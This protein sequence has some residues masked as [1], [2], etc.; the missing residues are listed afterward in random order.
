MKAVILD[1]PLIWAKA[2]LMATFL[3][4]SLAFWV[5][6]DGENVVSAFFGISTFCF[7]AGGSSK[8]SAT[9]E[10][11]L[12]STKILKRLFVEIPS[13][14]VFG[15]CSTHLDFGAKNTS[16]FRTFSSA[17]FSMG[18]K[19]RRGLSSG[20]LFK[21]LISV[22]IDRFG[23]VLIFFSSFLASFNSCSAILRPWNYFIKKIKLCYYKKEPN[24]WIADTI[25]CSLFR[26]W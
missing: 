15:I 8:L 22:R 20:K 25:P 16:I 7:L 14:F 2:F 19:R 12:L 21:L 13:V 9:L 11:G 23:R 24:N 17:G 3:G 26:S 1:W 4:F 6:K 5:K 18:G 10:P